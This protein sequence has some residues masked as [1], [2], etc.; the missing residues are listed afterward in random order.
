MCDIGLTV[1][2]LVVV[3]VMLK[4]NVAVYVPPLD[5][6]DKYKVSLYVV[7]PMTIC[8]PES[9]NAF[10]GHEAKEAGDVAKIPAAP[11]VPVLPLTV[12]VND[13]P[14][15]G[16]AALVETPVTLFAAAEI[17]VSALREKLIVQTAAP[18]SG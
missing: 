1:L 5:R 6:P 2:E 10:A 16:V 7:A 9:V 11:T 8:E 12:I 15:V 13:P 17:S 3:P 14:S 18:K 4:V